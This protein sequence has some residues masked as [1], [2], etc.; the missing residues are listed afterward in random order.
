LVDRLAGVDDGYVFFN[1][2][3]RACAVRDA[4]RFRRLQGLHQATPAQR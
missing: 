2:D 3:H 4:D 1:N